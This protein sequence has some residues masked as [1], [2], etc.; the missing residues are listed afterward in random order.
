MHRTNKYLWPALRATRHE[1]SRGFCVTERSYLDLHIRSSDSHGVRP[2]RWLGVLLLLL[3]LGLAACAPPPT[4]AE[5]TTRTVALSA[6][7]NAVVYTGPDVAAATMATDLGADVLTVW[8]A[9]V[10]QYDTFYPALPAAL[11]SLQTLAS[12]TV[13]LLQLPAAGSWTMEVLPVSPV[14]TV[15][16]GWNLLPWAPATALP[17]SEVVAPL[18][19]RLQ[20]LYRLTA[21][22]TF[23]SYLPAIPAQFVTLTQVAPLDALWVSVGA[24]S[25][26]PWAQVAGEVADPTTGWVAPTPRSTAG[27]VPR[28]AIVNFSRFATEEIRHWTEVGTAKMSWWQADIHSFVWP[29]GKMLGE[30]DF[31]GDDPFNTYEVVLT[32][33]AMEQLTSTYGAW[34]DAAPCLSPGGTNFGGWQS[35][36]EANEGK[37]RVISWMEGGADV[38]TA[39]TPCFDSRA[40]IYAF[41]AE[42]TDADG[43]HTY[44]HELYHALSNYLQDYC[45]QGGEIGV[46]QYEALRWVGEGTAHYFAYVVAAE[47]NGVPD[48]FSGMFQTA[49]QDALAGEGLATADPA[50]AALRLMVER[51]DLLESEILDGSLFETCD[52]PENWQRSNP[53]V[54]YAQDNWQKIQFDGDK[55]GFTEEALIR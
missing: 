29:L 2:S 4:Q 53:G 35:R 49:R 20:G 31:P 42:S 30:A 9:A 19:S 48:P 21:A 33:E 24:G 5:S 32:T 8:D 36:A 55:W 34:V 18:G 25:P 43:Q 38:A 52:W 23:D 40:V 41:P 51:G 11:N 28:I 1:A 16:A 14:M 10:Q 39:P 27:H 12:G 46:D 44:L 37:T 13:V 7:W 54:A 26:I 17:A 45:T 47:L 15:Q 50:A 3:I 6:G 22:G